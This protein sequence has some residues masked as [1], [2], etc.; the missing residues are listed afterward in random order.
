VVSH[1]NHEALDAGTV[2]ALNDVLDDRF[3]S[4]VNQGF[5]KAAGNRPDSRPITGSEN[6]TLGYFSHR[7]PSHRT[8]KNLRG[9][10][11]KIRKLTSPKSANGTVKK[12]SEAVAV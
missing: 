6:E 1:D 4:K 3:A 10:A 11:T 8:W 9:P 7:T 5:G 12:F 2:R